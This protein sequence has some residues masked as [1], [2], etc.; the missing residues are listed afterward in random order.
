MKDQFK[1]QKAPR[2]KFLFYLFFSNQMCKMYLLVNRG[3]IWGVYFTG[4]NAENGM[5]SEGIDIQRANR[6]RA[7]IANS[8]KLNVQNDSSKNNKSCISDKPVVVAVWRPL[9]QVQ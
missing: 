1:C 7:K 3:K 5:M 8:N 2:G 9:H 4:I 6:C